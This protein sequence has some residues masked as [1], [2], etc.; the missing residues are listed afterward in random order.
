MKINKK[1]L[2]LGILLLVSVGFALDIPFRIAT[3]FNNLQYFAVTGVGQITYPGDTF[4][5]TFKLKNNDVVTLP[6]LNASDGTVTYLY[7][8]YRMTDQAGNK[9]LEG[10][11]E[12]TTQVPPNGTVDYLISLPVAETTP[13]GKYSAVAVLFKIPATWDR[14]TNTWSFGDAVILDK[15]GV[16]FDVQTPTPPPKPSGQQLLEKI[17]LIFQQIL[18]WIKGLFGQSC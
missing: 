9:V 7:K 6:D 2:V 18:C 8:T 15:Q 14:T 17:A 1:I 13:S 4:Q 11:E 12:V 10:Y 3:I 5:H 16:T